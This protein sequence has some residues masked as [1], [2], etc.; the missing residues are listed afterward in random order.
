MWCGQK[1]SSKPET[2]EG[3]VGVQHQRGVDV[4]IHII[5]LG[6]YI[7]DT[8]KHL[9]GEPGGLVRSRPRSF[10]AYLRRLHFDLA[11]P[12]ERPVTQ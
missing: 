6:N 1:S 2:D 7:D 9:G 5:R 10:E 3:V 11:R 8:L 12:G 4:S